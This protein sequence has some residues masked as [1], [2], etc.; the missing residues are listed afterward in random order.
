MS[1]QDRSSQDRSSHDSAF[2]NRLSWVKSS[3]NSG[4]LLTCAC[5]TNCDCWS[6]TLLLGTAVQED[7]RRLT[8]SGLRVGVFVPTQGTHPISSTIHLVIQKRTMYEGCRDRKPTERCERRLNFSHTS[9]NW[10]S[11]CLWC[12]T[13]FSD[14]IRKGANCSF[15]FPI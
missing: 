12:L 13:L 7:L 9:V 5:V 4:C 14:L 3:W 8:D 11:P 15:F 10:W 1:S 2:K 6:S